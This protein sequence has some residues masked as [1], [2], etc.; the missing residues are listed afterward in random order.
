[1]VGQLD[2]NWSAISPEVRGPAPRTSRIRRRVS[3]ASA[4]K[5]AFGGR[6]SKARLCS[7]FDQMALENGVHGGRT[8]KEAIHS[9]HAVEQRRGEA[10]VAQQMVIQEIQVASGEPGRFGEGRIDAHAK[11]RV[12]VAPGLLRERRGVQSAQRHEAALRPVVVGDAIGAVCVGDVGL[13]DDEIWTVVRVER[14]DVLIDDHSFI[15]WRKVCGKRRE[16]ERREQGV[17]DRAP[18]GAGRF[19]ERRKDELHAEPLSGVRHPV[20]FT[21]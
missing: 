12:G 14:L 6:R 7:P 18:I 20:H 17:L 2:W 15:V 9:A 1:M 8:L 21:S 19:R 4:R 16:A 13:N 3:S 11:D 10:S 5:T